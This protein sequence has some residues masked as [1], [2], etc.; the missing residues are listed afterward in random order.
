MAFMTSVTSAMTTTTNKS[1]V[2]SELQIPDSKSEDSTD[3]ST[4]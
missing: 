3:I 1:A 4:S 2:T